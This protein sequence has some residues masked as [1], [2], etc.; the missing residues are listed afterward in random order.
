MSG[1]QIV[2]VIAP[3]MSGGGAEAVIEALAAARPERTRV[4]ILNQVASPDAPPEPIVTQ[5]LS[6]GIRASE[7]RCGRR[8]YVAEARALRSILRS[9]DIRVVH[10][11]GYHGD[12]VAFLATRRSNIPLV[13]TVHGYIRRNLK[14]H[15]YNVMDRVL[16]TRFDAV[17]AVSPAIV[18]EL[19]RRGIR[20]SR[21]HLVRN[22]L[23]TPS[24]QL[25]R[26]DAR[27]KLGLP[28]DGAVIGWIG[29]LSPEKGPDLFLQAFATAR[30]VARAVLVGEGPEL[31]R[32]QTMLNEFPEEMRAR[33][34][35][36]GY[37]RDAG[38]L[39]TAFDLLALSS[40]S[41]GTPMV[42]LEAVASGVPVVA[43]EVGGIP[44]LLSNDT[45]WLARA[46]DPEALG[47][48][49]HQALAQPQLSAQKAALAGSTLADVLNPERW[50]ERV[51]DVYARAARRA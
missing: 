40:R 8:A 10:S 12:L 13:S 30:V 25:S 50:I 16:L 51:E 31:P 48:A 33:I 42:I 11:H 7:I 34:S 49:L 27:H 20:K 6:R 1:S 23:R 39:I 2:H 41:E 32:L 37:Q 17:I 4:I 15:L 22:G 45:A 21:L 35:L 3:D 14:E 5:L 36:V 28:Q 24:R 19:S 9:G 29:R 43:F 26:V 18:S 38:G 47:A 46:G 44:D